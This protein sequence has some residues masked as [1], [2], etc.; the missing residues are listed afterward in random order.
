LPNV[1]DEALEAIQENRVGDPAYV[2]FGRRVAHM[3]YDPVA[4]LLD[5]L[6]T[7]YGQYWISDLKE[8]NSREQSLGSYFSL[9]IQTKWSLDDGVT[10]PDFLPDNP[11][12]L[13]SGDETPQYES[14]LTEQDWIE[15]QKHL[16]EGY[17]PKLAAELLTKAHQLV[18]RQDLPG[19]VLQSMLALEAALHEFMNRKTRMNKVLAENLQPWASLALPARLAAISTLSGAVSASQVESALKLSEMNNRIIREGWTPPFTAKEELRQ[20]M[21]TI[22][23]L[24]SGPTFKFPNYYTESPAI[25]MIPAEA[26]EAAEAPPEAVEQVPSE[27]VAQA[28]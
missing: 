5:V 27:P 16:E 18:E 12:R 8:W 10:W 13:S 3:I 25:E 6:R 4:R 23:A 28:G 14:L 21:Q 26:A 1:P 9:V 7:N 11:E 17:E 19:A 2:A 20:A 22:A 24:L 15:L